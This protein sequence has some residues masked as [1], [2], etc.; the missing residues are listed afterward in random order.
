MSNSFATSLMIPS[1]TWRTTTKFTVC[2]QTRRLLI[3]DKW[4]LGFTI[5]LFEWEATIPSLWSTVKGGT[6]LVITGIELF[7]TL[8]HSSEFLSLH[9]EYVAQE[10]SMAFLSDDGGEG[11]NLCHCKQIPSN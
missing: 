9:P 6:F 2:C 7:T 5:S 10:N 4:S 1:S 8:F 3:L 11:Y